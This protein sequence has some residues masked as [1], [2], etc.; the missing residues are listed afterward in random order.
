MSAGAALSWPQRAA[1]VLL[2]GLLVLV[3]VQIAF[4]GLVAGSKA[5]LA[6]NT[7]PLMDGSFIPPA[8]TLFAATPWIENFAANV[9]LVQF[10]HR[11]MAYLLLGFTFWHCFHA[12]AIGGSPAKRSTVILGL[13]L[14]Q[15]VLG[16]ITLLLAVPLWAGLAHQALAMIVLSMAVVHVVRLRGLSSPCT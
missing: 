7:W 1:R 16:I 9:A 11:M 13:M 12:R 8:S 3:F 14:A 4:G 5:G 2:Y 10:N 6:Y 15:A